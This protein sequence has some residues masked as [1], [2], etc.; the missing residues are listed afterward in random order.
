[1]SE[2]L[3][4][5]KA[6][7]GNGSGH[8]HGENCVNASYFTS[9][10]NGWNWYPAS[11]CLSSTELSLDDQTFPLESLTVH[12]TS[13]QAMLTFAGTAMRGQQEWWFSDGK[14]TYKLQG[15]ADE[16]QK[17]AADLT[18]FRS[19]VPHGGC[20]DRDVRRLLRLP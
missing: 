6:A 8:A 4:I 7:H 11:V 15:K 17:L 10:N 14:D 1:V 3:P 2:A 5:E 9:G 20:G 19:A 13:K 12:C 18:H 16:M